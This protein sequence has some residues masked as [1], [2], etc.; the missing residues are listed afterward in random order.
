MGQQRKKIPAEAVELYTRYIH[1]EVS[2]RDF[3]D[4]VKRYAVA[5]LT[6]ATI[7]EALTPNYALGQ[8]VRKDDE[9]IKASYETVPSPDGH[10]YVRGYVFESAS[11]AGTGPVDILL[12]VVFDSQASYARQRDDP[13]QAHWE[14]QLAELI[15]HAPQRHEG[16]FTELFAQGVHLLGDQAEVFGD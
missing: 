14:R 4:G 2:R 7:V 16:E 15:E 13:Q 1:G 8:Q 10:G 9:R 12:I 5:G 6:A 11:G 3:L